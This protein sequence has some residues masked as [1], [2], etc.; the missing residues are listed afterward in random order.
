MTMYRTEVEARQ[1]CVDNF[2]EVL[3][4]VL[5]EGGKAHYLPYQPAVRN[6]LGLVTEGAFPACLEVETESGAEYAD[7]GDW[8]FKDAKNRFRT[9]TQT[10]FAEMYEEVG[11]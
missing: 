3:Q 2:E 6:D 7:A 11:K 1:C 5:A 4:W 10:A 9:H 8:V